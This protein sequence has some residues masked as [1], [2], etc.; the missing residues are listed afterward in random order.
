M[1]KN[2][3]L[4]MFSISGFLTP[5]IAG[6]LNLALPAIGAQ[7]EMNVV[8]LGWVATAF[9][10]STTVFL[11]PFGRLADIHG[12]TRMFKM[13]I[14][15]FTIT[16][17]LS[18]IAQSG[19]Q[20]IVFRVLQGISCAMI[21]GTSMAILICVFP[22]AE[23]GKAIGLNVAAVYLGSSLGPV[24]GGIMTARWGWRS[25]F[26]L[27]TAMG[28][29]V[30]VMSFRLLKQEWC[31]AKG[32]KFDVKGSLLYGVAMIAL[33]YGST[34][35]P[36]LSGFLL[37]GTGLLLLAVFCWLEDKLEHPVFD[38]DLMLKNRVFA[39][40]NL[41]ALINYSA[42]FALPF[43]M[44]L[45]LQYVK[46]MNPRQAGMILLAS[47]LMMML[48]SPLAGRLSDRINPAI[49]ATTGMGLVALALLIL[50]IVIGFTTSLTLIFCLLLIF[51]TGLGL[52]SSPNTNA[53]LGAL[54]RKFLGV[55]SSV[56]STM[57]TVGQMFSMGITMLLLTLIV[58]KVQ[59]STH[60]LPEFVQTSRIAFLIF[61]FLCILGMFA[62]LARKRRIRN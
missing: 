42:S 17:F 60:V 14:I 37:T 51:G 35:I 57:R 27:V 10:L 61:A 15:A 38:I 2:T 5:F 47:P 11:L 59:I 24:L 40:S 39:F 23:R 28:L 4:L 1:N 33:I 50:G 18:S 56:L 34:L 26:Y 58:G 25:L 8:A 29:L 52:F 9:L 16:S 36:A 6:A 3:L 62:S 54:D 41:A 13:G 12:R 49:V 55:G 19:N 32:E 31:D 48:S 7:F 21:F 53:A 20:L 43:V 30:I 45:Y 22:A 46:A 44:S